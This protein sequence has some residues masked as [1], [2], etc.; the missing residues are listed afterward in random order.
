[1][2]TRITR[3]TMLALLPASLAAQTAGRSIK[4]KSRA[5]PLPSVGE[6]VRFADPATETPVVRLTNTNSASLLPAPANRFVSVKER[7]LIFS[8]NRTGK[9]T[10]FKV[11]LRSGLL[12]Q[13][14][15]TSSLSPLSLCLARH[16]RS[17]YFID[18][19]ELKE[20]D[21]SRAKVETLTDN[22]TGFSPGPAGGGVFAVRGGKLQH[23]NGSDITTLAEDVSNDC[24]GRPGSAM[25]C[26]FVRQRAAGAREFWFAAVGTAP[27]LLASGGI[28]NPYWTPEGQSI[29]FLR[30]VPR[31][32]TLF[33]E[34]HEVAVAGGAE[35]LVT[36]T[37][38]FAAF[39]PN[40]D[41]SVFV[42]A[43]RSKAQPDV[44]LLL[45]SGHSEMTLCEHRASQPTQVC[46]VFSPDARR[47]YFESDRQ[48][49]PAIYSVNVEQLVEPLASS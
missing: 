18:G 24:L 33:S 20:A 2:S 27:V 49:R 39:S 46:P 5:K 29:V 28:S 40:G 10:P 21:L 31:G 41:G 12:R 47:V 11:D 7:F 32:A 37:S 34:I 45:R 3:R 4:S 36:P 48:G 44:M 38:Q 8:S 17:V 42:G 26:L 13:I 1:V 35:T 16:E 25:G 6:F 30:D 14:A 43:S 19:G 9:F 22:V 15:V 23:V